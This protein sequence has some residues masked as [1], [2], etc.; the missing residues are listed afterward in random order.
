MEKKIPLIK[1]NPI[2]AGL[3]V[4]DDNHN[5]LLVKNKFN[6][7]KGPLS[8]PKGH[9]KKDETP[10]DCA[11]RETY[12]ETGVWF[13]KTQISSIPFFYPIRRYHT[14]LYIAY[15]VVHIKSCSKLC[16]N[17]LD[18]NEIDSAG[19]YDFKYAIQNIEISQAPLLLH[20]KPQYLD[21][22]VLHW[23]IINGYVK[24]SSHS[25]KN[26]RIL[27]YTEKCK[28]YGFWNEFTLWCRG[29]IIENNT[30]L[31]RPLKKFF[32]LKD[33]PDFILNSFLPPYTIS[34]KIDGTLGILYWINQIPFIA[35]KGSFHSRQAVI[36]T[37]ILFT[38]YYDSIAILNKSYSYFFE[39]ISPLDPHII[40][41]G[42]V[43]DIILLGAYDNKLFRDIQLHELS[44]LPFKIPDTIKKYD[45]L[46]YTKKDN[47]NE[48]GYVISDTNNQR[49]KIKFPTYIKKYE[50]KNSISNQES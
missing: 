34:K 19:I 23:H 37:R 17:P 15:F 16:L 25:T 35:T 20:I 46:K 13:D 36:G 29:L 33:I 12:E 22:R 5:I 43:E 11:I 45:Y 21:H 31:Y 44:D 4:Y 49:I 24:F 26:I 3:L 7:S 27:T 50:T 6:F 2:S 8:I 39:I 38:K 28:Q 40:D 32:I 18:R 42:N 47:N 41:Y 10:L 30:I 14:T 9:L 1:Q 48:E